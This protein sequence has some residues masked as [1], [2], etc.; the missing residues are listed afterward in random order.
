MNE[1]LK[2]TKGPALSGC[3][4][5]LLAA[6]QFEARIHNWNTA[7]QRTEREVLSPW[8]AEKGAA[9]HHMT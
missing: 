5:V 3:P 8:S 9:R 1:W 7:V 2:V 4:S 6:G